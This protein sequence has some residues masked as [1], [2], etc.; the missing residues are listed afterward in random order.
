MAETKKDYRKIAEAVLGDA[1][2]V[3]PLLL[4]KLEAKL[5]G[6]DDAA[7]LEG[8]RDAQHIA[9]ASKKVGKPLP[10][11]EEAATPPAASEGDSQ[12]HP[13]CTFRVPD[14]AGRDFAAEISEGDSRISREVWRWEGRRGGLQE[15]REAGL[16]EGFEAGHAKGHAKGYVDGRAKG[17]VDGHADGREEVQRQVAEAFAEGE[18]AGFEKGGSGLYAEGFE[19]GRQAHAAEV[20]AGGGLFAVGFDKGR[21]EGRAEAEKRARKAEEGACKK[22]FDRGWGEGFKAGQQVGYDKATREDA[23]HIASLTR[24]REKLIAEAEHRGVKGESD[25][26]RLACARRLLFRARISAFNHGDWN[27]TYKAINEFLK[28]TAPS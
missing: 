17:Y 2:R 23:V 27:E 24:D 14:V 4:P 22:G 26:D 20:R 9:G 21:E 5:E 11:V 16:K 25:A 7:Y 3:Y 19:A 8:Y 6:V 15:G 10:P 1:G 13:D 28:E 18:A 12:I